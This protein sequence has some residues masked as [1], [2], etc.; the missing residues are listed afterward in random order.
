MAALTA[1]TLAEVYSEPEGRAYPR[2][3]LEGCE[4]ALVLFAAAFDGRQ[5]AYW[6]AEAGMRATCVDIRSM[7]RMSRLYPAVWEFIEAD[8][9]EFCETT[10]GQWDI[11]SIDCPSGAF[12]QCADMVGLWCD[13]ARVAVIL[14]NGL[15]VLVHPP[16][17]WRLTEMRRR[18]DFRGGVYWAVLER[19][20]R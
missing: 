17:G 1:E 4:S 20:R 10:G 15:D 8:A 13:L 9:F 3:I 11:V 14:G 7:N 6:I 16:A 5:D 12:Q 2:H 18:S 19:A